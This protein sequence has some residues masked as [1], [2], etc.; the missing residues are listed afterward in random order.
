MRDEGFYDQMEFCEWE[1]GD[2]RERELL[3]GYDWLMSMFFNQEACALN[4]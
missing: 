2:K 3:C 1:N 4:N